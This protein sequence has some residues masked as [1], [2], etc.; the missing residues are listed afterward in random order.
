MNEDT[1]ITFFKRNSINK[2][3]KHSVF[4]AF[5]VLARILFVSL[6]FVNISYAEDIISVGV[7][8]VTFLMENAPQA[9]AASRQLK[10]K[11]S[12]QEKK[13][14]KELDDINDLESEL[15]KL[16]KLKSDTDL[17]RQKER[18]IRSH[19]RARIRSL[20]D[21]RE[22]LRFA[23]DAALD[24]VQKEVFSAIGAVRKA[25]KIDIVLQDYISAS[26]RADITPLVLDFLN[27]KLEADVDV[28][29]KQ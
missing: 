10:E 13:L 28:E 14:S 20:Q 7:V 3:N 2:G 22:E 15:K 24:V 25:E 19:K 18:E 17:I 21:F 27:K 5:I 8:N 9:E 11:F 29:N 26:K 4:I 12:P 16:R 6:L 1:K 23:R